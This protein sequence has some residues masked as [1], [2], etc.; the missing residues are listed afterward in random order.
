MVLLEALVDGY[1]MFVNKTDQLRTSF[2]E[3]ACLAIRIGDGILWNDQLV[4]LFEFLGL[5]SRDA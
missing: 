4:N 5:C 1:T 3:Q 2:L